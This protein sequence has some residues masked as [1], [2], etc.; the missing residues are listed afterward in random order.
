VRLL[1][2]ERAQVGMA[3]QHRAVDAER[4]GAV[5]VQRDHFEVDQQ[6]VRAWRADQRHRLVLAPQLPHQPAGRER[7]Q[8]QQYARE[9][10]RQRHAGR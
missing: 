3:R 1:D 2:V 10:A 7:D 6:I 9:P 8:E 5:L 4:F